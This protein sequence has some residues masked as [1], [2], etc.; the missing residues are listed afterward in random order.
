MPD[1][2]FLRPVS[3][4]RRPGI[5]IP[6]PSRQRAN[7]RP[8][9]IDLPN[10]TPRQCRVTACN[11]AVTASYI[12]GRLTHGDLR[13]SAH[14]STTPRS[15]NSIVVDHAPPRLGRRRLLPNWTSGG[16]SLNDGMPT[17]GPPFQRRRGLPRLRGRA[18]RRTP[19]RACRL[20]SC[21]TPKRRRRCAERTAA[22]RTTRFAPTRLRS[23]PGGDPPPIALRGAMATL[24]R[25]RPGR[26]SHAASQLQRALICRDYSL[27]APPKRVKSGA[28]RNPARGARLGPTADGVLTGRHRVPP[29]AI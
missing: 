16:G 27:R 6:Q 5:P 7:S 21:F 4:W 26:F 17:R 3:R 22:G 29:P 8:T 15:V 19:W 2:A 1:R 13:R 11:R 10:G 18:R 28:A 20:M 25:P 14:P 9:M 12:R 24:R 23:A